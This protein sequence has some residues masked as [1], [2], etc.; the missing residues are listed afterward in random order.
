[1]SSVAVIASSRKSIGG[2]LAELR[3]ALEREG[4][5][6]P[7]WYEVEKSRQAP[8]QVR[9]A[10]QDGAKLIFA[11]G[12]DG[13]VQ[14]CVGALANTKATL[15]IVPA[16]TAN[17]LAKNLGIPRNIDEA[18]AIGLRGSRRKVDVGRLN[19]ERFAV[20]AGAGFDA[21]MVRD[22]DGPLKERLGRIAYFWA[23]L[24]NLRA[25]PF[26]AQIDVDGQTWYE[27]KASC[28]LLGNVGRLF[29]GIEVFP[30]AR[31][32]DGQL[33]LGVV[34]AEGAIEWSRTLIRTFFGDGSKSP[35]VR[36]TPARF[37]RVKLNRK[38]LYEL[39]GGDRKKKKTFHIDVEPGAIT[40][41][42]PAGAA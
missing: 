3:R 30:G 6:D 10:L 1:M 20:M 33:E 18:V 4:V 39:D 23:G 14:R 2:G 16:G 28:I 5:A 13:M 25:K 8:D 22:A 32:D 27:G 34:T 12:G 35:F 36:T 37:V 11:W 9:R 7:I 21:R 40:V 31:T 17:L 26:Q 19:G 15:A 24:K 41:C 38:V 42:V 29:A